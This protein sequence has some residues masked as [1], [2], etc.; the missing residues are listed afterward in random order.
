MLHVDYIEQSKRTELKVEQ[1][2]V[3]ANGGVRMLHCV[4][5]VVTELLE[6]EEVLKEFISYSDENPYIGGSSER[7]AYITH[8]GEELGDILWYLAIYE[9]INNVDFSKLPLRN[10]QGFNSKTIVKL[11]TDL[12]DKYKKAVIYGREDA[13]ENITSLL[14]GTFYLVVS[15]SK[16]YCNS[17]IESIQEAN[18]NKLRL[19][20]PDKWD[21]EHEKNR[22]IDEE[23][24]IVSESL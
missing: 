7:D 10:S 22:N 16:L 19:R 14:E 9:R 2:A 11:V 21:A 18:I 6:L 1:D 20:Y 23:Q 15:L 13:Y 3:V 5:G 8:I 17:D 12:T 4:L 24:K